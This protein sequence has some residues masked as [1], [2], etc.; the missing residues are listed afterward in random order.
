MKNVSIIDIIEQLRQGQ[1]LI[2][3]MNGQMSDA[4]ANKG[5]V[6]PVRKRN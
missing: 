4:M 3:P 1:V 2:A 6:M 5:P